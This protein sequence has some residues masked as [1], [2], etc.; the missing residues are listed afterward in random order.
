MPKVTA[1]AIAASCTPTSIW[2]TAF[3]AEPAP[4]SSPNSNTVD[5]MAR[6]TGAAAA[7]ASGEPE[8]MIESSPLAARPGPP[9]TGASR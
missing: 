6:S 4:G 7:N 5:D 3:I 1:S 9:E 2:F 8:A